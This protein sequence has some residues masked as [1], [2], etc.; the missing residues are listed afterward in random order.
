MIP[1]VERPVVDER[2]LVGQVAVAERVAEEVVAEERAAVDEPI[3][4]VE[5][6]YGVERV[7]GSVAERIP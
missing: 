6:G 4:I 3:H 7:R 5:S 1:A 2:V